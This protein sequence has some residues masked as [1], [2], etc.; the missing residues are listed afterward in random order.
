VNDDRAE[1]TYTILLKGSGI[2]MKLD[3]IAMNF[4]DALR[5]AADQFQGSFGAHAPCPE[6]G[7]RRSEMM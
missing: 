2:E 5:R 6:C 7:V 1:Q 3:V 4:P